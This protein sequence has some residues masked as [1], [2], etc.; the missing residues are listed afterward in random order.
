MTVDINIEQGDR[1]KPTC[2]ETRGSTLRGNGLAIAASGVAGAWK[3]TVNGTLPVLAAG[4]KNISFTAAAFDSLNR[5]AEAT[6][7]I[8]VFTNTPPKFTTAPGLLGTLTDTT[9]SE[10]AAVAALGP[11][12]ATDKEQDDTT[13][14]VFSICAGGGSLPT[15]L[16]CLSSRCLL[17]LGGCVGARAVAGRNVLPTHPGSCPPTSATSHPL[18]HLTVHY[19]RTQRA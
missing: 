6:Y 1:T 3:C 19:P 13:E 11:L 4:T 5:K 14:L 7:A 15:G 8:I 2:T 10:T 9:R 16:V 12:T 17:S 18:A